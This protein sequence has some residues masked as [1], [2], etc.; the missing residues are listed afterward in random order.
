MCLLLISNKLQKSKGKTYFFLLMS[1]R[2][3]YI[4]LLPS[5]KTF[6]EEYPIKKNQDFHR[7]LYN[8]L[9]IKSQFDI[10]RC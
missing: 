3:Q 5:D 4:L 1:C 6:F 10:T 7:V 2:N 9:R 8:K